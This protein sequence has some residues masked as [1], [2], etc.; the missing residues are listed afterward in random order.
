MAKPNLNKL[1]AKW[2]G[3]LRLQDTDITISYAPRSAMQSRVGETTHNWAH[4]YATIRVLDP[5]DL[6]PGCHKGYRNVE[7]TVVHELLH[8]AL[9]PVNPDEGFAADYN[10]LAIE[11]IAKGLM[12]I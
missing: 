9:G 10:E 2:Q 5:S 3:R 8:V 1:L 4:G 12:G 11:K 6:T 7:L